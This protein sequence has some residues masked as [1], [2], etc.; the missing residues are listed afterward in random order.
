MI[1]EC[2]NIENNLK[3][4][5]IIQN[6]I[7]NYEQ[8]NKI[9]FNFYIDV[10]NIIDRIKT[11]GLLINVDSL[12]L[13]NTDD[14]NKFLSLVGNEVKINNMNLIYRS[15]RDG[16]NYLNIVNKINNKSNLV[17]IYLTGND[18]I[19]GAYIKTKL[20]DISPYKF[21]KDE[22]AFAFSLNNNKKYKILVPQNAIA[23]YST[24]FIL[25]GNSKTGNGF[26]YYNNAIY[27]QALINQTKIYDFGKNSEL[28]EGSGKF[29]ELEIFE[30][31]Q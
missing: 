24:Y 16:F 11:Y 29:T 3:E 15:S 4:L 2:I 6:S 12:I 28:T 9:T 21:Y 10:N 31:N 30:L 19:F 17:F 7:N 5:D 18:R 27:D 8:N 26:Y 13:K 20:D 14:I 25:I 23:I 1:N 22:N